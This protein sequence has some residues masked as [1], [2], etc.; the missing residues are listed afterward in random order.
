MK[1]LLI[2]ATCFACIPSWGFA[3]TVSSLF[4]RGY[5]VIPE[6]Q[7]VSLG[8]G[9]FTFGEGWRLQLDNSV[10][11]N[12]VAVEALRD[13]LFTRFSLALNPSGRPVG[14]LSLRIS[15]GTVQVGN[16]ADRDKG[17]LANQAYQMELD[18][19]S[20]KITAN[21]ST[22]LFYGVETLIQLIKPRAGA[23]WLPQ[24][25][26]QDWPDL[27]LRQIYW[28]DAHHLD[29]IDELK[30]A[31]RQAAF[32]KINGFAIKL[33]GHFQYKSAPAVVEPYAL[34]PAQLQE[35]TN[36][37]LRYHV[38]L[39]PY[40][41]GPAHIAFI[42]KHPEYAKLREFPES[43]YELCVTNPDSYKLLDGMF[44]DLLDANK[45]VD[46]FYLS[47]DE[48]YYLGLAHNS[49]CNEAERAQQLGSVSKLFVEFA[50]KAGGYLNDRG[51]KVI[52]WGEY[53]MKADDISSLPPFLI[54][55]EVYG[56]EFDRAFRKQRIRQMIY[57][58][59]EGEEKLFPDYFILPASQ[60]L[61]GEYS[62]T[63]RVQDTFEK[64]SY[65]TSRR[66]ADLMG[67]INAG[68]ADMG[69]HTETFWLG[70]V[71]ASSAGWHPGT[72]DPRESMSTFYPLFY[73]PGVINMDKVYQL[74]SEQAQFW[75]DSWDPTPSKARKPIW[76]NSYE[77]YNPPKP[78]HDQT[79]PLPSA[80]E[81][82]LA[83][84]SGWSGENE[85]RI[86]LS[87]LSMQSNDTL[88]GL[89]N[90]NLRRARFNTYNL[91]V[92]LTIAQLCRQNL[93]MIDGV[94]RMDVALT[95]ASTLKTKNPKEAIGEIDKALDI[96]E[97]IWRERNVVLK[98]AEATW[99]KS[100]FPR[101]AEA[102]GRQFL[103]A[104]DDVKDHLPDRT[105]DLS[106]LVHRE[107]LLPFGA[108][109]NAI[110]AA[111]NQFAAAH[112]MPVRNSSFDWSDLVAEAE[113]PR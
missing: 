74:L 19:H 95:S 75:T 44:Q 50:A 23:L 93:S 87:A 24:G 37:G 34:S 36:Y 113:H 60:R 67:E 53:P 54:N 35:L 63:P 15:P 77:I 107:R 16:A 84:H 96:A 78:A 85:N 25:T 101:I 57:T 48:P 5:T 65:D 14:V 56:P 4:A 86:S 22:G 94:H 76:G 62:G 90:E 49:Q 21:A 18:N 30:R 71:T 72:P 58:S 1:C 83:Y 104:L 52:F 41:D 46:Y 6:P 9:D 61:H 66:D 12:D 68:W 20:I 92:Y 8:V 106:Y 31:L 27:Q 55:G 64:I 109:V 43:N 42:L 89:I 59:S 11:S 39:I 91:E 2:I 13:D 32:Y 98:N 108:W 33:E 17:K 29:R 81:N 3:A 47:T 102:N 103:H 80:P 38:Q 111:R 69:L 73:G 100:W 105:V 10:A 7:K 70:Y 28:D 40:L 82:D 112:H 51:R 110:Q 99:Y 88:I 97:S 45:G 26:I 79:L